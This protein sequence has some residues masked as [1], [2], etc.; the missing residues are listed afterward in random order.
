MKFYFIAEVFMHCGN[1]KQYMLFD[2]CPLIHLHPLTLTL[3]L[4][5]TVNLTLTLI[6]T[7]TLSLSLTLALT[8]TL[9]VN[10]DAGKLTDKY[11]FF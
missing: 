11:L 5:L 7:L 1:L 4:T 6:L 3:T 10:L 2:T 9:A 8:L